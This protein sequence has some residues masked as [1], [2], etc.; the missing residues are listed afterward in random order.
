VWKYGVRA[1]TTASETLEG[2]TIFELLAIRKR[3]ADCHNL[4]HS[5]NKLHCGSE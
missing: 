4:W 1:T 2:F 5:W 3:K